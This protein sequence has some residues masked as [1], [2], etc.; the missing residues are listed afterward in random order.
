[1]RDYLKTKCLSLTS[2]AKII[3]RLERQRLKKAR[4]AMELGKDKSSEYNYRVFF[5]L[6]DHRIGDVRNEARHSNI[7][8]GFIRGRSYNEIEKASRTQP[9][10]KR[11]QELVVKYGEGDK[12]T[13]FD[14]YT[15]W[16]N[17]AIVDFERR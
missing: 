13:L 10:W 1:M 6:R 5:G 15:Q 16:K 14:K 9:N 12:T 17:K 3:R 11:I 2:E 7:A 8:Y 4:R